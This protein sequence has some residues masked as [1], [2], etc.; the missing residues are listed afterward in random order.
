MCQVSSNASI[1]SPAPPSMVQQRRR[2]QSLIL[3]LGQWLGLEPLHIFFTL[4]SN[5]T[6]HIWGALI[7]FWGPLGYEVMR[8]GSGEQV[9]LSAC[10]NQSQL[11]VVPLVRVHLFPLAF[12]LHLFVMFLPRLAFPL[13]SCVLL[14]C[15]ILRVHW[16]YPCINQYMIWRSI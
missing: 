14:M 15:L 11:R 12:S 2:T 16:F 13:S 9:L 8:V 7:W 1:I 6:W 10:I 4:P 3:G 5:S